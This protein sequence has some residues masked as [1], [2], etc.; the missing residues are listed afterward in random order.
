MINENGMRTGFLLLFCILVCPFVAS[1]Q[2]T[3]IM[4]S[5]H[6]LQSKEPIPFV[7]IVIPG[8]TI[9]IL[10]DFNGNY[11][12]EFGQKGDSIKA[13]LIGYNGITKKIQRNQFQ[14]INFELTPQNLNLPEVTI[15]YQGNPA[16]VIIDKVI[17]NKEKNT[18]QSFQTYQYKAYTKIELD[19][20]NITD[21]F[22]NRKILKQFDF[23]WNYLDTSTLNGKTYLPVFITETM[24]DIYF[25]KSPRSRK[26]II[27]ASSISGL[28][29]ASVSQFLGNLSEQVDVYKNF[30]P[31]FEKNFVSPISDAA[32]FNYK[33]YLVDSAYL[34]N[35]WCYH[36]MFKPRRKQELTFTGN[37]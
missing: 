5:V 19:A 7:N 29:N 20:N 2:V 31:L 18:L 35:K 8:T 21:Q 28:K 25:R 37:L 14:T 15:R 33:F 12:L 9:G 23:V 3:K 16:E 17:R 4:G 1:A 11:A 6:D 10:T 13:F 32:I 22:K 36:I 24:S 26:E 34:G 30:I 27:N